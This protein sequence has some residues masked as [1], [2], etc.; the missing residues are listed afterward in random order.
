M[1]IQSATRKVSVLRL[2][3][4]TTFP[5]SEDPSVYSLGFHVFSRVIKVV[6]GSIH[7]VTS[8]EVNMMSIK[9]IIRPC[10]TINK[11]SLSMRSLQHNQ[12][13]LSV[14]LLR[15]QTI[16]SFI[17]RSTYIISCETID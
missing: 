15:I 8:V 7:N 3:Q 1:T 2:Y 14:D 10:L 11:I 6:N 17:V 4:A 9:P 16:T 12:P 13:T 5:R